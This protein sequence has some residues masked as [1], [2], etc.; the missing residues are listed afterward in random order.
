MD[1]FKS[2]DSEGNLAFIRAAR[3]MHTHTA[4]PL[5]PYG[6]GLSYRVTPPGGNR[7]DARRLTVVGLRGCGGAGRR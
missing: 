1:T 3:L 4:D 7:R 6:F 2:V 5:Y